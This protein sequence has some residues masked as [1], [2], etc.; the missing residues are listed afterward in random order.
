MMRL[1]TFVAGTA[2]LAVAAYELQENNRGYGVGA[3]LVV[4]RIM[5]RDKP[6]PYARLKPLLL[7]TPR[8]SLTKQE[9][10]GRMT[11]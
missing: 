7:P 8:A 2:F 4:A 1:V 3:T 9:S 6:C 10:Y 5:G 11:P